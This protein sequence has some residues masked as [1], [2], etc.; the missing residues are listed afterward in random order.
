V[1]LKQSYPVAQLCQ[2]F[3][4]HLSSFKSWNQRVEVINPEQ[5]LQ[6]SKVKELFN[7]S[8]G[9][10]GSR[11][12][13]TMATAPDMKMSCYLAAKYIEKLCFVSYQQLSL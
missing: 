2:V 1:K 8:N 3:G 9:S 6:L 13:D 4:V 5:F 10:S 11:S 7:T 12:I